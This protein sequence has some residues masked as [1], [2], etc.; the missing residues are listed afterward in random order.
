[1]QHKTVY[2]LF[3]KF[4]LHVSVSTTPIIGST[5]NCNYSLRYW[6]YFLWSYLPPTWPCWREVAAHRWPVPEGVVTVL[7]TPD[8]GCSCQPKH[9]EWTCRIINRNSEYICCH[10]DENLYLSILVRNTNIKTRL[11]LY[12]SCTCFGFPCSF[13]STLYL[14]EYLWSFLA[15][16][17]FQALVF[18]CLNL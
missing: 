8:D 1:M 16:I 2:I 15:L 13:A 5:Q 12:L 6:S 18:P 7:C 9:V 14:G 3:C 11:Q 17:P 4:T 10:Y